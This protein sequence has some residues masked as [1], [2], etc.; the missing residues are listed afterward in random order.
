MGFAKE[1]FHYAFTNTVSRD[2]FDAAYDGFHIP[3]SGYWVWNLRSDSQL[4]AWPPGDLG[5][6]D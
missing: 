6:P 5:R 4:E 1:Q 2:E 3:A